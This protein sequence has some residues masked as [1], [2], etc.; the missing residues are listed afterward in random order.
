MFSFIILEIG[1]DFLDSWLVICFV[2]LILE[3]FLYSRFW[4]N[5]VEYFNVL[6]LI[7]RVVIVIFWVFDILVFLLVRMDIYGDFLYFLFSL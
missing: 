6:G 5:I 1:R 3:L 4:R 2:R 7:I